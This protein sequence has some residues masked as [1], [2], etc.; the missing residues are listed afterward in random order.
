MLKTNTEQNYLH[1]F[2]MH[3]GYEA[4]IQFTISNF[5]NVYKFSGRTRAIFRKNQK[6]IMHMKFYVFW[7]KNANM[8]FKHSY[9]CGLCGRALEFP[10]VSI[11]A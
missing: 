11:K 7:S 5:R 9:L 1:I 2:D 8:K 3:F 10:F 6:S 4:R